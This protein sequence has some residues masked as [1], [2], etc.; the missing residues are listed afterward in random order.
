M[1][2]IN[3]P[4]VG[5]LIEDL[6]P[7]VFQRIKK[8]VLVHKKDFEATESLETSKDLL[9]AFH[10]RK[11]GYTKDYQL[12]P[13]T[14][15]LFMKEVFKFVDTFDQKFAY[16]GKMFNYTVNVENVETTLELERIWLNF[17][18]PGEFLPL[19]NHSGLYSFV[20]WVN[21][22]FDNKNEK[23]N[24]PNP[25]LIKNRTSNFEFIYIDALGKLSNHALYVDKK[26][27]GRM[28]IFPADLY[29]QVYP[30]YSTDDTRISL[31]GNLRLKIVS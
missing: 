4:N 22:P 11:L 28:A 10:K 13:E 26:W 31:A 15:A 19:H 21:I 6:N 5:F 3:L 1:S 16:A 24:E 9:R 14:E 27:E 25:T 8:E 2:V 23:D 7:F 30:Y 18:R 12:S 20:L 17:Q 29:H